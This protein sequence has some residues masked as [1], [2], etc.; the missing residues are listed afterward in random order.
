[1]DKK[2]PDFLVNLKSVFSEGLPGKS[3]QLKMA[4]SFRI[5]RHMDNSDTKMPNEGAVLILLYPFNNSVYSVLIER[6]EY[7]G[8]HSSQM[9]FPGG[10]MEKNDHSLQDTAL[11]EAHEE[12]GVPK[13]TVTCIGA[14]TNLYIPVSNFN[15]S[16]FLGFAPE[17]PH[18]IPHPREVKSI[19]EFDIK[20]LKEES[21]KSR[22][23]IKLANGM[24]LETPYYN[25]ENKTVWGATAM[26][27]SELEAITSQLIK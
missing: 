11:R 27:I 23:K 17:R 7:R 4:P 6:A 1:M 2:F 20:I 26:I 21:T 18:F 19:I 24:F 3:A 13:E 25:I 12:I 8:Y 15:V 22:K 5:P 14:I 10:K 9:S 16:P